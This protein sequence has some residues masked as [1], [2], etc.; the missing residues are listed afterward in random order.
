[1]GCLYEL[2]GP[3]ASDSEFLG[4]IDSWQYVLTAA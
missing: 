2:D 3:A 4:E 1:M